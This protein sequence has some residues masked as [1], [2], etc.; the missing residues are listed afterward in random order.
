M[1]WPDSAADI[2]NV[3]VLA[4]PRPEVFRAFADPARLARWWGPN[5]FTNEFHSFDFRPGGA[6]KFTMRGPDGAAFEMSKVFAEIVAP[7]RIVLAHFQ[8]GHDFT[9]A[10]S[11]EERGPRTEVTWRMRFADAAEGERL[12]GFLQRANEENFDRLEAHLAESLSGNA[13]AKR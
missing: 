8:P 11:L 9:L 1:T 3:R 5:G 12:R 13:P 4:W 7:A 2:V 10:I 6:W